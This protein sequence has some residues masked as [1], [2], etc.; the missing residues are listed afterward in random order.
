MPN[1]PPSHLT[2][3]IY[4]KKQKD[5][6][7]QA[8]DNDRYWHCFI[9]R[10]RTMHLERTPSWFSLS[11]IQNALLMNWLK[12]SS[13]FRHE[14]ITNGPQLA[15]IKTIMTNIQMRVSGA[16]LFEWN[17]LLTR[18]TYDLIGNKY[19]GWWHTADRVSSC[20]VSLMESQKRWCPQN[21]W[22][23]LYCGTIAL[24]L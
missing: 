8:F 11:I 23:I 17:N 20:P 10:V 14:C 3:S 13:L 9:L 1:F 12:L 21:Y 4:V 16:L 24:G 18:F 6:K 22:F 15:L 19:I 7:T 2:N 5:I